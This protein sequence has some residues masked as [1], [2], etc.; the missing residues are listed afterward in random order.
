L[1]VIQHTC[2]HR[3]QLQLDDVTTLGG[4]TDGYGR[5]IKREYDTLGRV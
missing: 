5:S 1:I 2:N 3:R 4:S